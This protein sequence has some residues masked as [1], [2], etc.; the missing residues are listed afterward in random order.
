VTGVALR[1]SEAIFLAAVVGAA[2]LFVT[3][4][5]Q[6]YRTVVV[7]GRGGSLA[8]AGAT[9]KSRDIDREQIRWMIQG[10]RLS[11]HEAR[12]YKEA[13]AALET[14]CSVYADSAHAMGTTFSITVCTSFDSSQALRS[15]SKAFQ[16][17]DR[18]EKRISTWRRDSESSEVN[19]AAGEKA[20]RVGTDLFRIIEYSEKLS[21]RSNGAFDLTV[22]PLM[23]LW[24]FRAK[25]QEFPS[26]AA[27]AETLRHVGY[28]NLFMDSNKRT[29]FLAKR[30]M[31][32]DLSA[33]GKGYGVD[34][35][36]EVLEKLGIRNFL[37]SGSGD[38]LA[39]GSKGTESWKIG[40]AN[41]SGDHPLQ[42]L[43][44]AGR[45]AVATSGNYRNFVEWKGKRRGHILDPRSGRPVEGIQS[46]SVTA[47]SAMEA[48]ALATTLFVLGIPKGVELLRSFPGVEALWIDQAGNR[49]PSAGWPAR[50]N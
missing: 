19:R 14:P 38:L 9:G 27:V 35:A 20:V 11:G 21:K 3:F 5:I 7:E 6:E 32:I 12:F 4:S 18:L 24:G 45:M 33:V 40:I 50:L 37:I 23:E 1:K 41:P 16:E 10:K 44:V 43:A 39:S 8:T 28:K 13:D 30:G 47:A 42:I 29:L 36:G 34:C 26:D 46:V 25:K 2:V 48:D 31:Q 49:H 15:I 22:G 17:I